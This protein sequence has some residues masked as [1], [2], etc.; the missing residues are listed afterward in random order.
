MTDPSGHIGVGSGFHSTSAIYVSTGDGKEKW[1]ACHP[2]LP[3]ASGWG[4]RGNLSSQVRLASSTCG[5][6][7]AERSGS[8]GSPAGRGVQCGLA[9]FG[10][11]FEALDRLSAGASDD[12]EHG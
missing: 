8:F 2:E 11:V 3:L 7:P 5:M 6:A 1:G 10:E 12:G 4:H 9:V